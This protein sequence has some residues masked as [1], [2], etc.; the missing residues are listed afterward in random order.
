MQDS[1]AHRGHALSNAHVPTTRSSTVTVPLVEALIAYVRKGVGID[2]TLKMLLGIVRLC[3]LYSRDPAGPKKYFDMAD[4]IVE[5][6]ML[7]N[8]G[9]PLLTLCLGLKALRKKGTL[10]VW[11]WLLNALSYLLR[12]P[13]QFSGDLGFMQKIVFS[14]WSRQKLS[15]FY[16]FFKSLSLTCC[17]AADLLQRPSLQVKAALADTP[18]SR[19]KAALDLR[20]CDVLIARTLCD[21]YVYYKWI[22]GYTPNRTLEYLSG[23]FS[24]VCGMWLVWKDVR[25]IRPLA[26]KPLPRTDSSLPS[27]GSMCLTA[28]CLVSGGDASGGD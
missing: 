21:M 16:R 6:R 2:M 28:E 9:R 19:E 22:P 26:V 24:G 17:V 7:C 5:C 10:G 11:Y 15:F 20:V 14:N 12:V 25:Y 13:E 18:D 1:P 4:T 23:S 27:D 3:M 8:F